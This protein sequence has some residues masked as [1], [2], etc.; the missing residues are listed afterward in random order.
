MNRRLVERIEKFLAE[1]RE[2]EGGGWA[3]I[4]PKDMLQLSGV[5]EALIEA[6]CEKDADGDMPIE[7]T[8][9]NRREGKSS[10][11]RPLPYQSFQRRGEPVTVEQR[12]AQAELVFEIAMFNQRIA[13]SE[14]S[15]AY[16]MLRLER[17]HLDTK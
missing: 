4:T 12:I 3:Q 14:L 5:I 17:E 16:D 1:R 9:V 11:Y 2:S 7:F 8:L 15:T 13:Q 10:S 6:K